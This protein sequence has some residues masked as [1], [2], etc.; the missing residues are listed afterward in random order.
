MPVNSAEEGVE[1]VVQVL[2]PVKVRG[3]YLFKQ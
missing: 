2:A 1:L 3:V